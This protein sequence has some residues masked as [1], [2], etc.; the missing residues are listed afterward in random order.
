MAHACSYRLALSFL[1]VGFGGATHA[2][3]VCGP[4]TC[5]VAPDPAPYGSPITLSVTNTSTAVVWFPTTCLTSAI[6][7]GSPTGPIVRRFG[8]FF[9][10]TPMQPGQQRIAVWDQTDDMGSPVPPGTYYF[11]VGGPSPCWVPVQINGCQPGSVQNYG[12]TC[13]PSA[14]GT[15]T[16]TPRL[17][18]RTCPALGST[19]RL[20]A[21]GLA[22]AISG[23]AVPTL[24]V[25]G[26]SRSTW[27]GVPLPLPLPGGC[28]LNTSIDV[29]IPL[30]PPR[31]T[32]DFDFTLP[33]QSFLRGQ[34]LFAQVVQFDTV[35]SVARLL[36][37]DAVALTLY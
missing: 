21:T 18:A 30:N 29:Q 3:V 5:T 33:N 35:S 34:M 15:L 9:R 4:L 23:P 2:Q 16:G 20:S 7:Q 37:T 22:C 25:L 11:G 6:A 36:T 13:G 28:F 26:V 8:C 17:S 12:T 14:C 19:L 24:L 27:G 1:L 32:V 10:M 31:A